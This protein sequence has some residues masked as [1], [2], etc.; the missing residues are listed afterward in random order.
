MDDSLKQKNARLVQ[1][2]AFVVI[3]MFGFGF[4]LVPLYDVL[5]EL[6]GINGKT[7]SV[8]AEEVSFQI[9]LTR[10]INVELLTSLNETTPLEFSA[11][12]KQ[13]KIH[14]GQYQTV[15]FY[16][17]N[18]TDKTV[19][20]QAIPSFSP[21]T[22]ANYFNKIECFCFKRQTFQPGESKTMPMRFV[23]KPDLPKDFKTITLSYTFFDN[24][25]AATQN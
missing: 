24:T 20:A 23:I 22:V 11:E 25:K 12:A 5:C 17:K 10:E 14:P 2:L 1:I 19:V 18:K 8:A 15:N 4:A 7:E 3:G 16:A 21:G 13:L 6:T 9:D